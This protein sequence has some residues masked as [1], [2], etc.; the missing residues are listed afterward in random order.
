[1]H[2]TSVQLQLLR[3]AAHLQWNTMGMVIGL[4]P[5]SRPNTFGCFT[6]ELGLK[7]LTIASI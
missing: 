7:C 5:F 6:P 1:M 4:K 3:Q 2:G